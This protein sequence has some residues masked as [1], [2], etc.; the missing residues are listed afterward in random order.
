MLMIRFAKTV[1][2][3]AAL[4]WLESLGYAVEYS[5]PIAVGERAA[6]KCGTV[7]HIGQVGRI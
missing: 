4:A 3:D 2:G 7:G 6:E 1:V 5:V